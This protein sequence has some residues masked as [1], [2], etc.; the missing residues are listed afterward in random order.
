MTQLNTA[1]IVKPKDYFQ[2]IFF[3]I[4]ELESYPLMPRLL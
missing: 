2:H 4:I 3:T 1:K